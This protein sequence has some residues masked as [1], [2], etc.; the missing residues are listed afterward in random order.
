MTL[1]PFCRI[2]AVAPGECAVSTEIYGA[3]AQLERV[4]VPEAVAAAEATHTS[5]QLFSCASPAGGDGVLVDVRS[6]PLELE[7][8]DLLGRRLLQQRVTTTG[9]WTLPLF[10]GSGTYI[11]TG[12]RGDISQRELIQLIR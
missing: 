3:T 7:L 9:L 5:R 2:E 1:L 12:R 6:A 11:L 8:Y 10:P 4:V